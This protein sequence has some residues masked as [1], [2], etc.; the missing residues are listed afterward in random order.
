[1]EVVGGIDLDGVELDFAQQVAVV[2]EAAIGRHASEVRKP[3]AA[4][5]V[6]VRHGADVQEVRVV[7]VE[8]EVLVDLAHDGAGADDTEPK[9]RLHIFVALLLTA[10]TR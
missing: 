10:E 9:L 6:R 8:V 4:L 3:V 2:G 7:A 5:L 1:M